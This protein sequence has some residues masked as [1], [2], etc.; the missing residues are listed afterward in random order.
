L[1]ATGHLRVST[2]P[3]FE[4]ARAEGIGFAPRTSVRQGGAY[5]DCLRLK[6]GYRWTNHLEKAVEVSAR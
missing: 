2:R 6:A 3:I 4:Q 1:P 5:D